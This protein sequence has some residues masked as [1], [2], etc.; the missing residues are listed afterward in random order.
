MTRRCREVRIAA[1][2]IALSILG[3]CGQ[4]ATIAPEKMSAFNPLPDAFTSTV[5]GASA[6]IELGRVLYYD[7]GLSKR[8]ELSCNSC[9]PEIRSRW[10]AYFAGA[11]RPTRHS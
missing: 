9:H 10:T 3:G 8:Q 6:R 2:V 1:R 11:R 5:A 4:K 7:T